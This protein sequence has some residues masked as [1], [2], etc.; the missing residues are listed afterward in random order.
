MLDLLSE[1]AEWERYDGR[2]KDWVR[3][4]PPKDVGHILLTRQGRWE[5]PPIAGV[6]T[7]PTLKPDG[8]ILTAPGYDPVTRLFHVVDETLKLHP[9]LHRPTRQ[10][11]ERSLEFLNKLFA[12]FPFVIVKGA[13]G[14]EKH[15]A[16]A[17]A[18]SAIITPVVRGALSVAPLHALPATTSGS[19]KSYLA[20]AV[21]TVS[22]GPP[23]PRDQCGA[24]PG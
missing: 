19:G 23:L 17:V 20:D 18:L 16:K 24:R 13:D 4:N 8:S 2:A 10:L 21:S 1:V 22:T 3:I 7:S 11:A 5:F 15:I 6:V 14:K 9:D 12:E